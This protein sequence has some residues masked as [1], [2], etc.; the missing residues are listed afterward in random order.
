MNRNK[1]LHNTCT[2]ILMRKYEFL[3][4]YASQSSNYIKHETRFAFIMTFCGHV[5]PVANI[6][7]AEFR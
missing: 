7:L 1:L 2:K 6:N 5:I 3:C 4:S